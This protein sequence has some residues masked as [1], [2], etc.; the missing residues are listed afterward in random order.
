MN[1]LGLKPEEFHELC[2][3]F[4]SPHLWK[5]NNNEWV[6]RHN[7]NLDGADD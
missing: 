2:D 3:D 4:R 1:Y 5:K 6:L 7:V